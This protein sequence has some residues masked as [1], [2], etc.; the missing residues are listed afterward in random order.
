[1]KLEDLKKRVD[2]LEGKHSY[3]E[4]CHSELAQRNNK[5]KS[6]LNILLDK[7]KQLE[8]LLFFALK[9]FAPNF[10]IKNTDLK[11]FDNILP[12]GENV[13]NAN[14]QIIELNVNFYSLNLIRNLH[15]KKMKC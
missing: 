15:T 12:E 2:T 5:I 8:S 13:P 3:L 14:N 4:I 11:F 10:F 6:E 7:E 9:I 1:M